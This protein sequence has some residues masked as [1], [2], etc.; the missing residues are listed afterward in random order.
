M[1]TRLA[2]AARRPG[3]GIDSSPDLGPRVYQSGAMALGKPDSAPSC[4][5]RAAALAMRDE[6]EAA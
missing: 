1:V 4:L 6:Q 5:L 3:D 2:N